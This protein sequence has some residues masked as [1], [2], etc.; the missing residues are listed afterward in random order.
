MPPSPTPPQPKPRLFLHISFHISPADIPAFLDALRPCWQAFVNE[1]ECLYFDVTQDPQNPGHLRFVEGWDA[2]REWFLKEQMRKA[3]YTPFFEAIKPM[4]LE[5]RE[6]KFYY[7][8]REGGGAM[9]GYV[10]VRK[11]S[12]ESGFLL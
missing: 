6:L 11:F 12:G 10:A 3:Y 7:F 5:Q 1:P 4:E 8:C 2:S 9:M